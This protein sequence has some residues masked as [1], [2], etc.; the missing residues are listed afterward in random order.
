MSGPMADDKKKELCIA[1]TEI[2]LKEPPY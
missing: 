2:F 1:G